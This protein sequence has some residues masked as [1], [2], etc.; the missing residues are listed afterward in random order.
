ME[1]KIS[2]IEPYSSVAIPLG[3]PPMPKSAYPI[4]T[5]IP[6]TAALSPNSAIQSGMNIGTA[7]SVAWRVP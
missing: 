7:S 3:S 1:R 4:A 5:T 2:P 6:M